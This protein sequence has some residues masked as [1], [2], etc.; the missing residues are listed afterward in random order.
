MKSSLIDDAKEVLKDDVSVLYQDES[1]LRPNKNVW[2]ID[3][4]DWEAAKRVAKAFLDLFET[5]ANAGH[6][7]EIER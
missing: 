7:T 6:G 1:G 3:R 2:E 4:V 5:E